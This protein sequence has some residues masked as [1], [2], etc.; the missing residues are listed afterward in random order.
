MTIRTLKTLT[1]VANGQPGLTYNSLRW[2]IQKR[3][4][5]LIDKGAL[6]RRGRIW[7]IDEAAYL[8]DMREQARSAA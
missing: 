8:E 1:Q 2:D 6:F 3:K 5:A 7:L 4:Q